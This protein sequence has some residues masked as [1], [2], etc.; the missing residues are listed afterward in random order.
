MMN[1]DDLSR[2]ATDTIDGLFQPPVPPGGMPGVQYAAPQ[3][4]NTQLPSAQAAPIPN[5]L[6]HQGSGLLARIQ[7]SLTG[8]NSEQQMG[9]GDAGISP[10]QVEDARP[11]LFGSIVLGLGGQSPRQVY[12]A[13]LDNMVAHQQHGEQIAQQHA[14]LANRA[15]VMRQFPPPTSGSEDDMRTWANR[16][17]PLFTAD[18]EVSKVL[19]PLVDRFAQNKAAR[20]LNAPKTQM[21][22]LGSAV[23]VFDPTRQLPNGTTGAFLDPATGQWVGSLDR[24]LTAD[25]KREN[26]IKDA[27]A[28][29]RLELGRETLSETRGNRAST[30]FKGGTSALLKGHDAYINASAALDQAGTNPGAVHAAIIDAAAALDPRAQLRQGTIEFVKTIDPSFSGTLRQWFSTKTKGT[31][32]ATTVQQMRDVLDYMHYQQATQYKKQYD[33]TVKGVPSAA[34]YLAGISPETVYG[35]LFDS[36]TPPTKPGTPKKSGAPDV[37]DVDAYLKSIRNKKP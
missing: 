34:P 4:P 6:V 28:E 8:G 14:I 13:R 11:G 9:Y 22:Q 29:Q 16:V 33:A 31:L 37:N 12:Q 26:A 27:E 23:T 3:P 24:G 36:Y 20:D 17:F 1:F 30:T 10:Q 18:P 21:A 7:R 15:A 5:N 25:Q 35:N 32:D 19:S 2:Q